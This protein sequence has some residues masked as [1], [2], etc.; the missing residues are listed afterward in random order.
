MYYGIVGSSTAFFL[1]M[2]DANCKALTWSLEIRDTEIRLGLDLGDQIVP[3][4][5]LIF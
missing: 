5:T 1:Q 2:V 3:P 4:L